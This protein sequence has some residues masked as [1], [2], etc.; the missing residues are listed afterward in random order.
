M[1]FLINHLILA[2]HNCINVFID[3]YKIKTFAKLG[4]NVRH[5]IN[6]A[7]YLGTIS[8]LVFIHSDSWWY[9]ANF[10]FSALVQ[11][12]LTFDLP[13][14]IRRGLPLFYQSTAERPKAFMDRVERWL[15][16]SND[17]K[18]IATVYL[19]LFCITIGVQI[20]FF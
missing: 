1:T 11:R 10:I 14:N 13:L 15:F 3:A 16:P 2:V 6:L 8:I 5:G 20:T 19:I 4:K 7:A 18:L 12:Q 17:G 9:R